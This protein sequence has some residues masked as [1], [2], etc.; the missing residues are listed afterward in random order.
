MSLNCHTK[1]A[2][3]KLKRENRPERSEMIRA[4]KMR[5]KE[6]ANF[7]PLKQ[8]FCRGAIIRRKNLARVGGNMRIAE[9]LCPRREPS[10][11]GLMKEFVG[12]ESPKCFF[13]D[14]LCAE[15]RN[16]VRERNR[17][18]KINKRHSEERHPRLKPRR[19]A[20]LVRSEKR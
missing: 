1:P 2:R 5:I 13:E 19:H 4:R 11:F 9:P 14:N 17:L 7:L 10:A 20:H 16:L 15:E 12:N 6:C 18:R 8:F 3:P